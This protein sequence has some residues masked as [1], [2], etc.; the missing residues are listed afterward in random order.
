MVASAVLAAVGVR[1]SGDVVDQVSSAPVQLAALAGGALVLASGAWLIADFATARLAGRIGVMLQDLLVSHTL[2]LPP[3][4]FAERSVG[5]LAD[6]VS[7]DIDTVTDGLCDQLKPVVMAVVG[8]VVAFG[9]AFGV[10][11]WLPAVFAVI[12]G[13][14]AIPAPRWRRAT[15]IASAEVSQAWADAAG[16]A[17]E[18]IAARDDLRQTLGRGLLMRRWGH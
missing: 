1:L 17:E 3:E 8:A 14:W 18:A 7:T 13:A 12:P 4:F 10:S 5:E 15:A 2:S 6:R 11:P 16:T 9:A